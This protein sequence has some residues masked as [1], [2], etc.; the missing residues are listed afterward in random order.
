M[1]KA[2]I[3]N[4]L[5][6][7]PALYLGLLRLKRTGHWSRDWIV[8][9][10]S[11][12]TIEGFPR[13]ANSFALSAFRLAQPE[14][15]RIATHVHSHAQVLRSVQLGIPTMVLLRAPKDACLSLA[16]LTCQINDKTP[17]EQNVEKVIPV[18]AAHLGNYRLFYDQV[19]RVGDAVIIAEFKQVTSDYGR[20]IERLNTRFKTAF[21]PYENTREN[22][23][24]I[25]QDSGFHLSPDPQ[26]DA[27]KDVLRRAYRQ[28]ELQDE[29][30]MAESSYGEMLALENQ[31]AERFDRK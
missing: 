24:T 16:A 26:R 22:R 5:E 31:Q 27:L 30:S 10:R 7:Y 14:A 18:L 20:I 9:R 29:I 1:H 28:S 15:C 3:K 17:A 6:R 2:W 11:D 4:K 8:S 12:I 19:K 23:E 13:S 21:V 25:F